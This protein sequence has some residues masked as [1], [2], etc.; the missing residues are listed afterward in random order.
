MKQHITE[1]QLNELTNKGRQRLNKWFWN[2]QGVISFKHHSDNGRT[3]LKEVEA[4]DS[5][6]S[7]ENITIGQMIEFLSN[8]GYLSYEFNIQHDSL[9]YEINVESK[10]LCDALW[11][12]CVTVLENDRLRDLTK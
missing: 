12:A 6:V 9:Y 3:F 10:E 11:Q 4:K 7:Y 1:E 2:K 5:N 8:Y